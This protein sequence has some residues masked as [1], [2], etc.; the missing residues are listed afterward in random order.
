MLKSLS[1]WDKLVPKSITFEARFVLYSSLITAFFSLMNVFV[2]SALHLK[3]I[4]IQLSAIS[5]LMYVTV[6]LIGRF[7]RRELLLKWL[8][9]GYS[10][11]II[12]VLWFL[13]YGI[14]GP[15]TFVYV[16]LYSLLTFIWDERTL[17][18]IT[19][20]LLLN[21]CMFFLVDYLYPDLIGDYPSEASRR[22]DFFQAILFFLGVI[23]ILSYSAKKFYRMEFENAKR[24]DRLKSA[25]LANMSHEIR[26]PL[27]SI[28]GFSEL[29]CD[30]AMPDAK[31]E[32]FVNIIQ[33]NNQNLLR[34]IDD[35]LDISRIES[36]QLTITPE[37]CNVH[38]LFYN[39]ET[40]YKKHKIVEAN[41]K[42]KVV[43][44]RTV[45][46]IILD[47]DI[48]R[49]HQVMVNLLDNALKFTAE[50]AI[51][52]GF[53]VKEAFIEVYISDQ[54][55]GIKE[56]DISR[57]FNRFYKIE[58]SDGKIY[59]GTGIGLSLCKDIVQLLGGKIWVES[60]F[61][62]GSTFYFT[63]PIKH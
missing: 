15:A 20:V 39:L 17:I 11:L 25:F 35:I 33:D 46:D 31:R 24:S 14:K 62:K 6:F 55:I 18:K 5:F 37:Y 36:N 30:N 28:V 51:E 53:C 26:T 23:F 3:L 43:Y 21:I 12:N 54:G 34:L 60:Q 45:Q 50:G 57:L 22:I 52:F 10:L 48:S 16:I 4:L 19:V 41:S 13:N 49:F 2:N 38:E 58:H 9:S 8:F 42:V 61:G 27:N 59:K 44:Q 1:I 40:S 56:E 29:L 47:T 7:T 63:L 32:R